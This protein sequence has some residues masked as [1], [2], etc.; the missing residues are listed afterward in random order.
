MCFV[1]L[2]EGQLSGRM[3]ELAERRI[4]GWKYNKP[5]YSGGK[6]TSIR[7]EYEHQWWDELFCF[8]SE[9]RLQLAQLLV[10]RSVRAALVMSGPV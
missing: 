4:N 2:G 8:D 1:V 5:I 9:S 6:Y 7:T 10:F 3:V